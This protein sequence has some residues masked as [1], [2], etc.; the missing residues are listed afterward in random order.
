MPTTKA[1]LAGF[2]DELAE[3]IKQ[4]LIDDA[5][6]A[7]HPREEAERAFDE[8]E[9]A[10]KDPSQRESVVKLLKST[11]P[12]TAAEQV[13]M[14]EAEIK[15]REEQKNPKA[16]LKVWTASEDDRRAKPKGDGTPD[17]PG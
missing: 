14:I 7:G 12:F 16:A 1:E 15:R 2:R 6:K 4:D 10:L 9:S 17:L 5:V 3:F 13:A 8:M 11:R